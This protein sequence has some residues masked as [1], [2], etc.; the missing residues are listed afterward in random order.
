VL[1]VVFEGF[2]ESRIE[3]AAGVELHVRAAGSG[4]PVVLLHGYPQSGLCWHRVAPVLADRHTVVVPDLRGYGRSSTPPDDAEHTVYSKR[5]MALD[6]LAVMDALGHDRFAVVGHDRGGRVAYRAALDHPHRVVQLCTLDII[7]TIE[8]FELL[9][10]SRRAA[11]FGFHWYF[12]AV[13]PPLPEALIGAEP[14]LYLEQVMG[15]WTGTTAGTQAIT[16]EAMAAYVG[17][18]TAAV[19]AAS[20]ADY[21]AGAT[22][23]SDLDA[24]DREVGRTIAC[25]VHALWGDRR[26]DT[27]NDAVLATWR[28]WTATD[29]PVT[30]RPLPCGH[31][32]P[33]ERPDL[34]ADELIGFLA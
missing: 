30:G 33:E 1:G 21:R 32:I 31:F 7:P 27:A 9:A 15:K 22:F 10:S 3:V 28:R 6:V 18:F 11:V 4:T 29:Q 13:P 20:C 24:A 19:I 14:E 2:E 17:D 26:S 16:P 23:D 5:Q 25:P 8:Q 12:L 34:C